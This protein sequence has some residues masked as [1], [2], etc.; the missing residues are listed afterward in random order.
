MKQKKI[1]KSYRLSDLTVR[2]LEA[3]SKKEGKN[4]T[5]ALEFMIQEKAD[6]Y[7]IKMLTKKEVGS[8]AFPYGA[9]SDVQLVPQNVDV[10]LPEKRT[11][12]KKMKSN[13]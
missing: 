2:R 7:G 8:G 13:D 10:V 6:Y 11:F 3:I 1:R 5:E 12:K 4:A 9:G